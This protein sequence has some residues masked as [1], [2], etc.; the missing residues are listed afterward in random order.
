MLFSIPMNIPISITMSIST[1]NWYIPTNMN[2][3]IP[4]P[5][6]ME[7]MKQLMGITTKVSMDMTMYTN[8]I[9]YKEV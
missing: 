4:I 9:Q 8:K 6:P 5:I 3:S 1:V 2:I 7:R